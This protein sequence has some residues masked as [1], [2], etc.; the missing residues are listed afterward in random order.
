M[1]KIIEGGVCA[2]NGFKAGAIHSGLKKSGKK[3]LA[4]I[5]SDCECTAAAVYRAL[6]G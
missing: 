5:V 4:V 6:S 3:D 2:A 1:I